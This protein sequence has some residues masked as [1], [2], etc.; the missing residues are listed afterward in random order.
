[1]YNASANATLNGTASIVPLGSDA[2]TLGGTGAG[3]FANKNVGSAKPVTVTGYTIGGADAGNYTLVQPTPTA[4]ITPAPLVIGGVTAAGRVYNATT[5]ASLGGTATVTPLAGDTVTVAGTGVGVFADKNVGSNKPVTVS[6]FTLSGT[7]AGN[8]LPVQP[9][10]LTANVTPA[11]LNLMGLTGV[12]R[13]YDG[14]TNA[15][16]AGSAVVSPLGTDNVF[17]ANSGTASFAD[18]HVGSNKPVSVS[19]FTLSGADAGNYTVVQPTGLTGSVSGGIVSLQWT[20]PATGAAPTS[21]VVEVGSLSGLSNILVLNTGNVA[22]SISGPVPRG[23]YYI[24]IRTR[25]GVVVSPVSNEV[26]I[27]VP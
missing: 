4:N 27:D 26:M 12:D 20:A 22:T 6:G 1:M 23:R 21:Y 13:T 25:A 24:R 5:V 10:G 17:V 11:N 7:D 9:A 8:Y 3:T 18:R 19:G 15:I 16:L 14:T 2:V